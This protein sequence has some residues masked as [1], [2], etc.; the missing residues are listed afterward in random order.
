MGS[1][2]FTLRGVDDRLVLYCIVLRWF[3]WCFGDFSVFLFGAL[4]FV[5]DCLV[6]CLRGLGSWFGCW[7]GF[8]LTDL[9]VLCV[10]RWFGFTACLVCCTGLV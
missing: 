3:V 9:G 10:L 8:W 1:L 4:G 6:G 2:L 7:G 5:L